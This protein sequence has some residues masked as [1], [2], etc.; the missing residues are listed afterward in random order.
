MN[1]CATK[2]KQYSNKRKEYGLYSNFDT[3]SYIQT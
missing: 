3:Y 1:L 2:Y